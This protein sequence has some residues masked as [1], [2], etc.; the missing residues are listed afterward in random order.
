M[1][2]SEK[3]YN[4]RRTP[5]VIPEYG[6]NIQKMVEYAINIKDREERNKIAHA[7]I[8]V[9]GQLNPHLRDIADFKHKLWDHLFIISDFKL[10]VDSPYPLPDKATIFEKP[11]KMSYPST[12][13][14]YKH[15]GK[16]IVDLIDKAIEFEEGEEKNAL[17]EVLVN[18]MKKT[19]LTFNQDSVN[20][21]QI[22]EDLKTLSK[23]K[24]AIDNSIQIIPT[25]EIL[26]IGKKK[27]TTSGNGNNG[28]NGN[29]RNQKSH[30][31]SKQNY[32]KRRY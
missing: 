26:A 1:E 30:N 22:L 6:R 7:I 29:G 8:S 16:T 28:G 15:Y 5:M 12:D 2:S 31:K 11:K 13:N 23:G 9:M 27:K 14:R 19:Y 3:D 10:D 4:T 21:D 24:L 17:I 18:L 32:K 20:D 25:N